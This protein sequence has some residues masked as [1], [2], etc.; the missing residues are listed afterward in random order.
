MGSVVRESR[1]GVDYGSKEFKDR[2][3]G[4]SKAV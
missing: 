4:L 1:T 2:P 3:L